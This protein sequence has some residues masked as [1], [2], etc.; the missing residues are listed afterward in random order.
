LWVLN[1][2]FGRNPLVITNNNQRLLKGFQPRGL[3]K[4]ISRIRSILA[5]RH[6]QNYNGY[7]ITTTYFDLAAANPV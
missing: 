1:G 4:E 6:H 7:K 5:P 2:L 3:L